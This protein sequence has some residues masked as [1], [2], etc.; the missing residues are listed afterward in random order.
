MASATD[1]HRL[2]GIGQLLVLEKL[3]DKDKA[4][5][6]YKL[7]AA[8]KISLVQY[9]VKNK[10]LTAEQIALTAAQSFGVS[11]MDLDCIEMDT[12]PAN[13]VNEKLI[14]RHCIASPEKFSSWHG[15]PIKNSDLK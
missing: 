12:I 15:C 9:L 11:M 10:V 1:E 8:E 3:L 7:A 6:L 5:E 14:R 2:Q 4:M 13:L